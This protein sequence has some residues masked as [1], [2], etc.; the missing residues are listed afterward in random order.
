MK[1][2][3]S[4]WEHEPFPGNTIYTYFERSTKNDTHSV[5]NYGKYD[6]AFMF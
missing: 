6:G 2:G 1:E 3:V 5:A 4:N